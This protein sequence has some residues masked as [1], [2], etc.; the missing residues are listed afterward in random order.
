M[1]IGAH[2]AIARALAIEQRVAH[3][4]R[5]GVS[6]EGAGQRLCGDDGIS[7]P[8]VDLVS[9]GDSARH[10]LGGDARRRAGRRVSGIVA[11]VGAG[12]RYPIHRDRLVRPDGGGGEARRS[13]ARGEYV[14][15]NAI[16]R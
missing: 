2:R 14:A 10:E 13:V 4:Q 6:A 16:I 5:D 7:R 1:K 3:S 12:D 9:G 15:G 11:G 8:V